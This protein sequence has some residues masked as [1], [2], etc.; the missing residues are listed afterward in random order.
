M[1]QSKAR[2]DPPSGRK[3]ITVR[4]SEAAQRAF[5]EYV[6]QISVERKHRVSMN[7]AAEE[8][9]LGLKSKRRSA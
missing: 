3:Q 6:M 5:Q 8:I 2:R 7:V 1:Q 9:F 4:V